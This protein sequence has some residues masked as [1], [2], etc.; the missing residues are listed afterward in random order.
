MCYHPFLQVRKWIDYNSIIN[1]FKEPA[2][3][4]IFVV[5]LQT[6]FLNSHRSEQEYFKDCLAVFSD[7]A[8][9]VG[10]TCV[11]KEEKEDDDDDGEMGI[12]HNP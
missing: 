2:S 4:V 5:A 3:S 11:K 6:K 8:R 12:I 7:S 9:F 10:S 1:K